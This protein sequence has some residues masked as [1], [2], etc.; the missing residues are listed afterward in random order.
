[1]SYIGA[2]QV[3]PQL[4]SARCVSPF[5][6]DLGSRKG[7]SGRFQNARE[8]FAR[9][10]CP[11]ISFN[12]R[13]N[14]RS[15]LTADVRKPLFILLAFAAFTAPAAYAAGV[16]KG[17][18]TLSV[19]DG[20]GKVSLTG[21]VSAFGRVDAGR[22]IFTNL[23]PFDEALPDLFDT[24]E[25]T[26]LLSDGGILCVGAKLRFR[27]L[28]AKYRVTIIGRGIDLSV[29]GKGQATLQGADA[30]IDDGSF[31]LN[32]G[33]YK[34]IPAELATVSFGQLAPVPGAGP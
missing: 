16:A 6:G 30:T 26:K 28:D 19:K 21:R 5:P 7:A 23:D 10:H 2:L 32:G 33:L 17:D 13:T 1:M 27:L 9:L 4:G 24:C 12:R 11:Y 18:G 14:Q 3:S 22:I 8:L 31:S 29:V 20:N 15:I 34:P 25:R